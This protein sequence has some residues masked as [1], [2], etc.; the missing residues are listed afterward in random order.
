MIAAVFANMGN[1]IQAG[2]PRYSQDPNLSDPP[3][4]GGLG[5]LIP[6]TLSSHPIIKQVKP[7][8]TNYQPRGLAHQIKFEL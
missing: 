4:S 3:I 8:F 1:Q 5:G 6:E 2:I 7:G